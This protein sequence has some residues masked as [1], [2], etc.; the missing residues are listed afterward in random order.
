MS[1][2][3]AISRWSYSCM[4][5]PISCS[6]TRMRVP[7]SCGVTAVPQ[8]SMDASAAQ[9]LVSPG[10]A[11]R[12]RWRRVRASRLDRARLGSTHAHTGQLCGR[13]SRPGADHARRLRTCAARGA[14]AAT[15]AMQARS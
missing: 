9:V 1:A 2:C 10:A 6:W 14:S 12:A 13:R 11:W 7:I 5:Q 15:A 3:S 8:G 4:S